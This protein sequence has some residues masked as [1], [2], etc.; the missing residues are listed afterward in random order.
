MIP[1]FNGVLFLIS[2]KNNPFKSF[3]ISY[4]LKDILQHFKFV[5]LFFFWCHEQIS[6]ICTVSPT[7]FPSGFGFELMII[8]LKSLF[9]CVQKQS[10]QKWFKKQFACCETFFDWS[11]RIEV[12]VETTKFVNTCPEFLSFYRYRVNW[13]MFDKKNLAVFPQTLT[14][15]R[16]YQNIFFFIFIIN[17]FCLWIVQLVSRFDPR[18][19]LLRYSLTS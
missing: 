19:V 13:K 6:S 16:N 7:E 2:Y 1:L 14:Y 10:Y 15:W 11:N 4:A 9:F 8:S 18:L 5:N 12:E 17:V 3:F